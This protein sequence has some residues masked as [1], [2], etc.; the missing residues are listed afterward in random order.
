MPGGISLFSAAASLAVN[1][2]SLRPE[3][4]IRQRE[5]MRLMKLARVVMMFRSL[6]IMIV[7][8]VLDC[9]LLTYCR[10]HTSFLISKTI[11]SFRTTRLSKAFASNWALAVSASFCRVS[12][13]N[14]VSSSIFRERHP[15]AAFAAGVLT[16]RAV[17]LKFTQNFASAFNFSGTGSAKPGSAQLHSGA[18]GA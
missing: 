18:G 14:C 13:S 16:P 1:R 10:N 2:G 6:A 17:F 7:S 8:A 3:P 4:D 12:W 15:L 9:D 11:G 5:R